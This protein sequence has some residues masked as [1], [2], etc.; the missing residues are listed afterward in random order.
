MTKITTKETFSTDVLSES[1]LV[2]VDFG[3]NGADHVNKLHQ[4]LKNLQRNILKTYLYA[5]LTLT[6]IEN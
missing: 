3:L 5:R 2:L 4:D 6:Q 1:K